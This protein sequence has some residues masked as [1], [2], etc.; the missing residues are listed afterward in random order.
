MID[1]KPGWL[2]AT[3]RSFCPES[4]F[5]PM[6]FF[7][8]PG[9]I[10]QIFTSNSEQFRGGK[11]NA[12]FEMFFGPNSLLLL[13]GARHRRERRLSALHIDRACVRDGT[14]FSGVS[15]SGGLPTMLSVR[16]TLSEL[17]AHRA[18]S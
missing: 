17:D 7:T 15:R 3:R 9:A 6:M 4:P 2:P 14:A 16:T 5:P 10:R 12:V 11:P 1:I 8:N 18:G 13:D